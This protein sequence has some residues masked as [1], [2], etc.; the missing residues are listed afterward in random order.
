MNGRLVGKIDI[1]LGSIRELALEIEHS[2]TADLEK[3]HR[4]GYKKKV[5]ILISARHLIV[6]VSCRQSLCPLTYVYDSSGVHIVS[7]VHSLL[8]YIIQ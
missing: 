2:S 1:P 7:A 5:L 6:L 3:K 4:A 8:L